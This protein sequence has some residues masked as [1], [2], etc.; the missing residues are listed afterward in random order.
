MTSAHEAIL[1]RASR[2]LQ[3]LDP[4]CPPRLAHLQGIRAVLFDIYG[5]L[6]I[7]GVGDIGLSA[8]VSSAP[9]TSP[10][11]ELSTELTR[12][13]A[14][15]GAL[16]AAGLNYT[17]DGRQGALLWREQIEASHQA[18]R[19]AG[20]SHPE[21]DIVEIWRLTCS[22]LLELGKLGSPPAADFDYQRLAIEFEIRINPV[23]PMPGMT[24]CL[25]RLHRIGQVLGIISNAQFFTPLLFPA[26][27]GAPLDEL[28][29]DPRLCFY[30]FYYHQAKP[31][32]YLYRLAAA[33]L[34]RR[35]IEP[36]A[37][38]YVGNDLRNDIWPAA[39]VGYK[40]A[41]F[42]GDRRSLRLRE[43]DPNRAQY[44]QPDAVVTQ[45]EQIP[46]LITN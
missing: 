2:P 20:I 22:R 10:A 44:G 36:A 30:S 31:G 33:A 5:T 38:L 32:C 12:Q 6:L 1:R 17:G 40:T 11:S 39:Q 46:T 15:T 45:L 13:A 27:V 41:L 29:F 18:D 4:A 37:V 9:E 25:E 8:S 43:D 28:G 14:F 26:V 23:W 16:H 7:S 34:A 21:V 24:D 42:A 19:T 3:P 35:G